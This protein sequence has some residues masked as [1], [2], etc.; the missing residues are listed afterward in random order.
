LALELAKW[1]VR[2]PG[3]LKWLDPPPEAAYSVACTLLRELG[4]LDQRQ[5]MTPH[6]RAMAA[7]P[8]HP[9]LG[10]MLL[11][12][13]DTGQGPAACDLAALLT[14]TGPYSLRGRPP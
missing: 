8:V 11:M 3:D 9:R 2:H 4:A 5:A 13:Q 1:G 6:G 12:G 10:H 14:E 7:M